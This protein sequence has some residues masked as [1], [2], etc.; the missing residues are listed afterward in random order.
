M[1][2]PT[3]RLQCVLRL[4]PDSPH[5]LQSKAGTT[6]PSF[7][8][9]IFN[10]RANS[11]SAARRAHSTSRIGIASS[12][13]AQEHCIRFFLTASF[14]GSSARSTRGGSVPASRASSVV[15][16]TSR[17]GRIVSDNTSLAPSTALDKEPAKANPV[18]DFSSPESTNTALPAVPAL[19]QRLQ[20]QAL[21]RA[22]SYQGTIKKV[23]VDDVAAG[24]S[25]PPLDAQTLADLSTTTTTT[26]ASIKSPVAKVRPQAYRQYSRSRPVDRSISG[27]DNVIVWVRVSDAR[28]VDAVKAALDQRPAKK[29]DSQQVRDQSQ[30]R[31][32][33]G[34]VSPARN[35]SPE[36]VGKGHV[37]GKKRDTTLSPLRRGFREMPLPNR[38]RADS[39]ST[40][41]RGRRNLMRV[42]AKNTE[43]QQPSPSRSPSSSRRS[44][45]DSPEIKTPKID[46][47]EITVIELDK[48]PMG[49][50]T[51]NETGNVKA[52]WLKGV[53]VES[54]MVRSMD[55]SSSASP[56]RGRG[57]L[58]MGR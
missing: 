26:M 12:A 31:M 41:G 55:R 24:S 53:R 52:K 15:S 58:M 4:P 11:P 17:V 28:V 37:R 14:E 48:S 16:K 23:D 29:V 42:T 18:S 25:E 56:G 5:L 54:Q 10:R 47:H 6:N 45:E 50:E 35:P 57:G 38:G 1:D 30:T 9:S 7:L 51:G 49:N 36:D 33:T 34:N 43:Q 40:R 46:D 20:R 22:Q 3:L 27:Q 21:G 44:G 32:G 8:A 2:D 13:K 39:P 19:V